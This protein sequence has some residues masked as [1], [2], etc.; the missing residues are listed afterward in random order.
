MLGSLTV[1]LRP[2]EAAK[3]GVLVAVQ[4]YPGADNDLPGPQDM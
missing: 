2:G 4:D 1:G 3:Y